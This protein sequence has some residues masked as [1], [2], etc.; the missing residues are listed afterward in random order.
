MQLIPAKTII[1]KKK[2]ASW[3]GQDYNMNLYKGCCHGCIYC[4]SR[5]DCYQIQDFDQ[6]RAKDNAITILQEELRRRIKTGV[7][8]TGAMSDPYNPFEAKH[9]FTREALSLI[10][11]HQFGISIATKSDLITRDIDLLTRIKSHSPVICKITITSIDDRLSQL[12]EPY[13]C[14]TSRRLQAIRKLS[15]A[16]LFTGILL[17][18]VL[19]YLTDTPENILGIIHAAHEN[20]AKFIYPWFGVSLRS[21][22]R[23]YFYHRL[24]ELF[25]G[26]GLSSLYQQQY[27][28]SYSCNS[29]KAREL[30]QLF[31]TECNRLGLLYRMADIIGA[32]KKGYDYT[33]LSLF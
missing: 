30:Q 2:D 11:L 15:E 10:D 3:F 20:G 4:D 26:Q 33:Q 9:E 19:P 24:E 13:V 25:P 18:P 32:Y 1:T 17:M 8:G 22:Q 7:I 27:G 23:E 14:P 29:P 31:L 21:G 6:V 28:S 12:L 16:D 5:S